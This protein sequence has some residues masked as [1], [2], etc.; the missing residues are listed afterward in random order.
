M[1]PSQFLARKSFI[2]LNAR[3]RARALLD[4]GT[5]RELLG[6][7][8]RLESPWLLM[9]GIVPQTDAKER[10]RTSNPPDRRRP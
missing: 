10:C 4:E 7:F 9:Q 2:D 5:Y 1:G 8:E 3:E 6:P